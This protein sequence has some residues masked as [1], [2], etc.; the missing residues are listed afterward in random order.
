MACITGWCHVVGEAEWEGGCLKGRGKTEW[1]E[2]LKV[3]KFFVV[4]LY[5]VCLPNM[6]S[7]ERFLP[8]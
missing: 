6:W 4:F 1:F 5:N 2:V 3:E 8:R 7:I